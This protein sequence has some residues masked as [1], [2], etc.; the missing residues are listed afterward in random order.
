CAHNLKAEAVKKSLQWSDFKP[1]V[2]HDEVARRLR[3]ATCS[4]PSIIIRSPLWR[5]F[6]VHLSDRSD[7]NHNSCE[8]SWNFFPLKVTYFFACVASN[9]FLF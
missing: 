9:F 5:A 2:E 1:K 8:I 4:K 7:T 6:L 3:C